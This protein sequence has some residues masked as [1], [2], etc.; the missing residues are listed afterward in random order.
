MNHVEKGNLG[1]QE[2]NINLALKNYSIM[3]IQGYLPTKEERSGLHY[4]ERSN[5][6]MNLPSTSDYKPNLTPNSST[7]SVPKILPTLVEEE[8]GASNEDAAIATYPIATM[9]TPAQDD[10]NMAS[11]SSS[12]SQD[13]VDHDSLNP[14]LLL[15]RY[16]K[17]KSS[18]AILGLPFG[19]NHEAQLS[20]HLSQQRNSIEAAMLLAN[21]NKLM[22]FP[23]ANEL[24]HKGKL[25]FILISFE[26]IRG[27]GGQR[28]QNESLNIA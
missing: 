3:D 16:D 6:R 25:S 12:S 5:D 1:K 7:S 13:P 20:L 19:L 27:E 17:R 11:S 14:A 18:P 21:F 9:V 24:E 22:A 26:K 4:A 15:N 10:T 23:K 28:K 8:D 2:K